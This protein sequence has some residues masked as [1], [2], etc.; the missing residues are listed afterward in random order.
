MANQGDDLN[1]N[2]RGWLR[3]SGVAEVSSSHGLPLLS[4][5]SLAARAWGDTGVWG[6]GVAGAQGGVGMTSPTRFRVV[7]RS[8]HYEWPREK[9]ESQVDK[10]SSSIVF[11]DRRTD[12]AQWT[13][14]K[15]IRA[16]ASA[17]TIQA[18]LALTL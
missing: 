3:G 4:T 11:K 9:S 7:T 16:I 1:D 5:S 8:T 12:T 2:T 15:A 18:V 6:V 14:L 17:S 10:V 13:E